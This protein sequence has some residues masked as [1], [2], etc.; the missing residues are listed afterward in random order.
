MRADPT[1]D[2]LRFE[3][4]GAER[5]QAALTHADLAALRTLADARVIGRAGVRVFREDSLDGVL[6][7]DGSIG[8]IA[9]ALLGDAAHPVRAIIFDKTA[10]MNW[11]VPWHQDRT[12]AVRARRDV[13]GFGPWLNKSGVVHVEPPF[14]IIAGM[15]TIRAHLDDCGVDNAPLLI[16]PGSH[17]RRL[18]R[19]PANASFGVAQRFSHAVCCANAGD[20]WVYATAIVHASE[21]ARKPSRRRVIQVD[22]ASDALP[23]GL[24]WLGLAA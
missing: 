24:E 12:I 15:I 23:G 5:H 4:D 10:E 8:R 6:G 21:R 3:P 1:Q 19:V 9:V 20:V 2:E 17:R 14:E 13:P 11:S 16:V 22:Y 18:G 7:A